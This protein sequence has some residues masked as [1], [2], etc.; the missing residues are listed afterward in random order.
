MQLMIQDNNGDIPEVDELMDWA[1]AYDM[2]TVPVLQVPSGYQRY[3]TG[4]Y[5]TF[6]KDFGIPSTAHIGPD[7]TVLSVDEYITD[8][9]QFIE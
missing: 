6:E 4:L 8:P 3:P 7:G 9:G 1:E 2:T 5:F